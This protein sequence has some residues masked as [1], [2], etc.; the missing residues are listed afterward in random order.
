MDDETRRALEAILFIADEPVDLSTL[1]QVLETSKTE[2]EQ[3][4]KTLAAR[5]EEEGR[6]FVV[7]EAGGGWRMYSAPEAAPYLE[8]WLLT[9][10]S[11]RLTQPALETLAVVAYKQPISRQEVGEIRGVDPD[12]TLRTLVA[13]GL[14]DEVGRDDGP[15]QAILYGTT[16]TFLEKLGLASLA[17]LPPLTDFLVDGPAPDEPPPGL[18]PAARSRLASGEALPSTG[19]GRWDPDADPFVDDDGTDP[20]PDSGTVERVRGAREREMDGLTEAL[21]RAARNAT[22][23]LDQA[24]RAV[25]AADPDPAPDTEEDPG[26]DAAGETG[27]DPDTNA[28]AGAEE[29]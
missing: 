1:C 29:T 13:R 20:G 4:L 26:D 12:A 7:R 22:A 21:E 9:G 19:R 10:R 5:C 8:R 3:E 6:G 2:V 25:A 23:S 11:G 18:L 27:D 15:G 24:L 28:T 17:E 14:V 16:T